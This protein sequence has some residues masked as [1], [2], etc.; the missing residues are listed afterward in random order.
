ML[1]GMTSD[2]RLGGAL[3]WMV[4]AASVLLATGLAGFIFAFDR[5][6]DLGGRY[7]IAVGFITVW[8]L[9]FIVLTLLRARAT[10]TLASA[11]L[12][13]WVTYRF[14]VAAGDG[15]VAHWPLAV[16][17]LAELIMAASFCGYM[18]SAPRPIAYYRRRL[19]AP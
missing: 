4:V 17:L 12:V 13:L 14:A 15:L 10:P 11:G 1:G 5:L 16:D 8:S 6:R 9:A 3:L 18:A 2:E 7:T 19:P